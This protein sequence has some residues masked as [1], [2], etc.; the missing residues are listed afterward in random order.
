MANKFMTHTPAVNP[1]KGIVPTIICDMD[2]TLCH[3]NGRH[4]YDYDK[5][6]TDVPVKEVIRLVQSFIDAS[7]DGMALIIL[8]G[9]EDTGKSME[10]TSKWL[11]RHGLNPDLILM[12]PK[13][14]HRHSNV[15]KKELLEQYVLPRYNV[16]MI[17]EDSKRCADTYREMGLKVIMPEINP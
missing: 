13:G 12:R 2:H 14:D 11:L 16:L 5:V 8:T 7:E 4:I 10:M 6:D 15:V 3:A 9:R 1:S 17:F